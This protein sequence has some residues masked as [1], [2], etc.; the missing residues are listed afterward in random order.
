M[1]RHF[2]VLVPNIFIYVQELY[3]W[4]KGNQLTYPVRYNEIGYNYT[5]REDQSSDKGPTAEMRT[6]YEKYD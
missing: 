6:G 1:N 3:T 4:D 2:K 5:S